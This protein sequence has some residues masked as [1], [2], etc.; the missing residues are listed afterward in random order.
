MVE[1]YRPYLKIYWTD[2]HQMF[3]I[4]RRMGG[5]DK[6]VFYFAI[7]QGMLPWQPILEAKSATYLYQS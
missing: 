6:L 2:R 3:I 5:L 4:G 7:P 1:F